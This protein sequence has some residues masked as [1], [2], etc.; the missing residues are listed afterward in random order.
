MRV[1]PSGAGRHVDAGSEEAFITEHYWGYTRRRDGSTVE[2]RV[3]HPPWRVWSVAEAAVT[4]DLS[5]VYGPQF[6]RILNAPPVSAFLAEG[7]AVTV[8][9]PTKLDRLCGGV[10]ESH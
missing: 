10:V 1:E 6:A 4:G 2:Y 8:F 3:A 5:Y 9:A 7:S